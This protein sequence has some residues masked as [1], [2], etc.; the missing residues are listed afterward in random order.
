MP[1]EE[2][3][4]VYC[5]KIKILVNEDMMREEWQ[6]VVITR[7]EN[8]DVDQKKYQELW[9]QEVKRRIYEYIMAELA[10]DSLDAFTYE[11]GITPNIDNNFQS[12]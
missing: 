12:R 9:A 7:T 5:N 1:E 6:P 11:Q 8:G 2:N 4:A 10:A 3:K